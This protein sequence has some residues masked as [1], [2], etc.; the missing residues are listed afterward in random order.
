[1]L[2]I[3]RQS[4]MLTKPRLQAILKPLIGRKPRFEEVLSDANEF[5]TTHILDSQGRHGVDDM[6][7][8]AQGSPSQIRSRKESSLKAGTYLRSLENS[9][10]PDMASSNGTAQSPRLNGNGENS[11]SFSE[12]LPPTVLYDD[13]CSWMNSGSELSLSPSFI[14]K[15]WRSHFQASS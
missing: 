12:E 15:E 8:E 13:S 4:F 1:M 10:N 3:L 11:M 2:T 7:T 14:E 9:N 5:M 6:K